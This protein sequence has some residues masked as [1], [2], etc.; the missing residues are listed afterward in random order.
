MFYATFPDA[1]TRERIAAVS[2]MLELQA[3]SR[4]VTPENYHMTLAFVGE[5]SASEVT[6]LREIG[7][8]QRA[9]GFTVRFDAYRYWPEAKVIVAAAREVPTA[10]QLLWRQLQESLAKHNLARDPKRLRPHVTIARKV[11]QAPVLQA[12]AA[13]DWKMQALSLMRSDT[14]GAASRYTVV[15]SWP[16]LDESATP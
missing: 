4:R 13:F 9:P 15:E 11:S 6:T 10:L 12:M 3:A 8:A 2:R 7:R 16:L 14:S 1:D 5:V